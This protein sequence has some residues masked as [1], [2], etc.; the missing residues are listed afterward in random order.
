MTEILATPAPAPAAGGLATLLAGEAPAAE[1]AGGAAEGEGSA[2][3]SAEVPA[4]RSPPTAAPGGGCAAPAGGVSQNQARVE[5]EKRRKHKHTDTRFSAGFL[6]CTDHRLIHLPPYL[7]CDHI[8]KLGLPPVT[9]AAVDYYT[10]QMVRLICSFNLL[11]FHLFS[12]RR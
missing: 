10:V 6:L 5:M 7:L 3:L 9:T 8:S 2:I 1:D 11:C 4:P 12:L